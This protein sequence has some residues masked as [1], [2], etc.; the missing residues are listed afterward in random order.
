MGI[1]TTLAQYSYDDSYYSTTSAV[2]DEA[3][4][5]AIVGTVLF[6]FIFSLLFYVF[7]A[8]MLSLAFH[9]GLHGYLFTITGNF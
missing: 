6:V 4:A 9:N 5:A 2:S 8:F 7:F 1:F 3:A